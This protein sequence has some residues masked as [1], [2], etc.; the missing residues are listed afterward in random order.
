MRRYLLSLL[1]S[2]GLHERSKSRLAA[3]TERLAERDPILG[4]EALLDHCSL[5]DQHIDSRVLAL[6]RRIPRHGERGFARRLRRTAS[7]IVTR[8]GGDAR[9]RVERSTELVRGSGPCA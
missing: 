1:A 6:G 2:A 4:A 8:M 9:E 5:E 7:G 3:E